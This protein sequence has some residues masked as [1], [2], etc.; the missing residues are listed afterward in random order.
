M[1]SFKGIS[2]AHLF[3]AKNKVAD[4]PTIIFVTEHE[5]I[6][7]YAKSPSFQWLDEIIPV[8]QAH[9]NKEDSEG[10]YSAVRLAKWGTGAR[11][12]DR[13]TMCFSIKAPDGKNIFQLLQMEERD[14]GESGKRE[15]QI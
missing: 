14:A 3:G 7:V 11:K 6:V 13:P 12:E 8:D 4:K 2:S 15:W 5:Y 9:F 10:N 1:K